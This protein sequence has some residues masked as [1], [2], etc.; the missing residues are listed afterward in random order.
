MSGQKDVFIH[1]NALVESGDVGAGTRVWAFAHIMKGAVV[2]E[3]CKVGDHAFIE[4]GAVLGDRVTVKNSCLIWHGVH[5]GD[6]VFVGPNVVFTNDLT[7]RARYQTTEEDW[8]DTEVAD[9]ASL[10]ANATILS[11]IHIGRNAFVGAGSVVTKDVPDHAL[12]FGNPA[13][14]EGWV[15]ACGSKLGDDLVCAACGLVYHHTE[16]G[17]KE[18]SGR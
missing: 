7:P 15:C 8:L 10:G 4:S 18:G 14:H 17:L 2:G 16:Q 13:R 11:G 12:V 5:L 3:S 6:D 1:P 9:G